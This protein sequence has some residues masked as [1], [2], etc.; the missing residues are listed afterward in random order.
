MRL[1]RRD[2][3]VGGAAAALGAAG[4]YELV[5]RFA[6][7]PHRTPAPTQRPEQHLLEGL[8]VVRD[9]GVE[10][11][12]P[13]LHHQVVTGKVR[14][15]QARTS[16]RAAQRELEEAIARVQS[17]FEPPPA[18]VALTVAWGLPYFRRYVPALAATHLPIDRRASRSKGKPVQ[19]LLDS[20]RFPSDPDDTVFE[21]NDVAVVLS[22]DKHDSVA[23]AARTLFHELDVFEPTSV[24]KGFVGGGF[25]GG[26][27]LPKQMA[28][29]AGVRGAD[30]IPDGAELFLGFTSTQKTALGP[31]RIANFE[32]LGYTDLGPAGYFRH[33]SHMHLSHLLED[34]EAW[35]LLFDFQDRVDT[36]FR[37]GIR[38][39]E[40]TQTIRE[41]A[42]DVQTADEVVRGFHRSGRIGHSGAVQP[43]SRLQ[44]DVVGS[45]GEL[46]PRGTA[47]PQRIDFNTVDN[48]FFWTSRP[49]RDRYSDQPAAGL[50]FAVFNPTSDDFHRTRL[51]L[52]GVMPDGRKLPLD[53]TSKGQGFNSVL[54][55]THRQNFLVPPRRHRSFPLVELI[56]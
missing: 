10:V 40:G 21:D 37:P 28:L 31:S 51:A 1:T 26:K 48:P 19:A 42:Q 13:P 4:V 24:R 8:R 30:L 29:A 45:D 52:D 34:L 38:V 22:S 3:V 17:S 44:H 9:N 18:G 15:G 49:E 39:V 12:I 46:Y 7:S 54:Q 2:V 33:G 27:S 47:V 55:T 41:A 25:G 50:H 43:A 32:T 35:Y 23:S 20:I 16:L 14:V 11:V 53:R 56:R 6:I 5:D 36:M